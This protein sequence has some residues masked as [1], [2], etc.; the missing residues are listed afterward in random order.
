MFRSE[1]VL[2]NSVDELLNAIGDDYEIKKKITYENKHKKITKYINL[3]CS[4]D[5]ET[6]SFEINGEKAACMYIWQFGIN[7]YSCY[8]RT[9]EEFK[10]AMNKVREHFD[11]SSSRLLPVYVHNLSF[12]FQWLRS[13]VN[14]INVFAREKRSPMKA[15]TDDGFEYRCS[16]V[17][18]GCSLE[19]TCKDLQKYK[20]S[21]KVGD[22]DYDQLRTPVTPLTDKEIGYCVYDV[23]CVMNYIKEEMEHYEND[24]TK[25]P[26][27]KTG[28]VRLRLKKVCFGTNAKK[29]RQIMKGMKINGVEEYDMLK[30]AFQGGFTHASW[31][32]CN[33]THINVYS[34]D[35]TSSYP[36]VL[37]AEPEF[38][39]GTGEKIKIIDEHDLNERCK[40]HAIVFNI[41][42]KGLR[43][44]FKYEHY[45]SGSKCWFYNINNT[46]VY[47]MEC[48]EKE[49]KK[50][51]NVEWNNG[52]IIRADELYTTI[53]NI[54]WQIIRSTYE[55]DSVDFGK[56][57]Q[58]IKGYLPTEIVKTILELY[59]KK[60]T[61]KDIEEFASEY[62]LVKSDIN[63]VYGDECMDIVSDEIVYMTD[64]WDVD[65]SDPESQIESYNNDK[66]RYKFYPWGVF[67]T[68]LARRNLWSGIIELCEDYLYCD[69]DSL[70]YTNYE[71]HKEYF[72]NYNKWITMKLEEACDHHGLDKTIVCPKTIKG[73]IK[74]LGVWD[75]ESVKLPES[76]WYEDEDGNVI[77]AIYARRFKTLGAK[78]YLVET[79]KDDRW[80]VK[81]TIAGVNKKKTSHW[82]NEDYEHA[83]DKFD[84]FMTVPEEYSGRLISTY[85]D[86]EDMIEADVTDY[87]GN[88]WHMNKS[89]GINLSKSD[90]N[91]TLS[92]LYSELLN[93]REVEESC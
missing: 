78:R 86:F 33:I 89:T 85:I 25:I 59:E 49:I 53:T 51:M 11:L 3:P 16:Y 47:L 14:F 84:N 17:L 52:K 10:T 34:N 90:Y 73:K 60:T 29:Y 75:D 13:H 2:C 55:W 32:N 12:E 45:L 92:P 76:E 21:K 77:K 28:K 56:G 81:C 6:S 69:T 40:T 66:N 18:S 46:G 61:L 87:L 88:V 50:Y 22:L 58:Y 64:K 24:I 26:M 62:L 70:K 7:G 74:P 36:T 4:F 19:Q 15:V 38:P 30:R 71:K 9:W 20:I 82:F 39:I 1:G 72:D 79:W 63:S 5:I 65:K 93:S 48:N 57:Y 91:L 44:K 54:D 80:E 37:C 43:P 35:F 27:T 23:Y 42:F 31:L 68:A 8:G 41:H 67:C 83:F